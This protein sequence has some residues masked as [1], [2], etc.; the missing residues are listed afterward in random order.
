MERR[1][2][3]MVVASWEAR[4]RGVKIPQVAG[5]YLFG[6]LWTSAVLTSF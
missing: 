4:R 5:R 2:G 3:L 6:L 1:A